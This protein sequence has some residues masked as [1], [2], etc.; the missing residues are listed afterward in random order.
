MMLRVCW[1]SRIALESVARQSALDGC[2]LSAVDDWPQADIGLIDSGFFPSAD[3]LEAE[4]AAAGTVP[5]LVIVDDPARELALLQ[6]GLVRPIDELCA[7]D[8]VSAELPLRLARLIAR[9]D[10]QREAVRQDP[11]TGVLN[12]AA[13][14]EAAARLLG[15]A[16]PQR[17]VSVLMLDLDWFKK[18]N[19][20]FGHAAGDAILR[21]TAQLVLERARG[22]E[23]VGRYGGEEFAVVLQADLER[24]AA[25]A[26]YLREQVEQEQFEGEKRVTVSI[27]VHCTQQPLT[28]QEAWHLADACL[29]RA[30]VEGRN[31]VVTSVQPRPGGEG[32]PEADFADFETRIRVIAER[33]G[34]EMALRGT[35]M[36]R[37]F[38][39]EADRDGLTGL[40]NRRYLDRRLP[41]ELE[42]SVRDGRRLSLI[43]LDLDHFGAV[44]RTYGFPGGDRA[45][46]L[47]AAS[48]L[49]CTRAVDW[50]ARYGGEEFC[51]VMP[52]TPLS[53]A[54]AVAERLRTVIA[55]QGA[56]AVDGR[57]IK[58]TA[59]LGVAEFDGG[60]GGALPDP[61]MLIQQASDRVREAKNGGRNQ[62]SPPPR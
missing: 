47:A 11:L 35:R 7:A 24:A 50:A 46:Q 56:R 3:Q 36:A 30:K 23:C 12:L 27:G 49:D 31:R 43:M 20:S 37:R 59:S 22:V 62:V 32:S 13:L 33:F 10:G 34:Q 39:E 41:R 8:R 9:Q 54:V 14:Q 51:L 17:P 18:I 38:R 16:S 26:E 6:S 52:D 45:L 21:H 19:D 57:E 5:R 4:L 42:A 2:E 28:V 40:F 58:V 53:E 60:R 44:N 29:Y 48:L 55:G 61:V 15:T 25:L 1:R